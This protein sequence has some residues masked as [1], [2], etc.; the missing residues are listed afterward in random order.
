MS[1]Q[2]QGVTFRNCPRLYLGNRCPEK[3]SL[4]RLAS[5]SIT[6]PKT[7]FERKIKYEGVYLIIFGSIYR[8]MALLLYAVDLL[9]VPAW[10]DP[11]E[12]SASSTLHGLPRTSQT[13][14]VPVTYVIC[15]VTCLAIQSCA[16]FE[17]RIFLLEFISRNIGLWSPFYLDTLYNGSLR[18]SDENIVENFTHLWE[19]PILQVCRAAVVAS[20]ADGASC[21]LGVVVKGACYQHMW[22]SSGKKQLLY[23]KP[24]QPPSDSRLQHKC[25]D[26]TF[27]ARFKLKRRLSLAFSI[28]HYNQ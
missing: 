18:F 21:F 23:G 2:T 25:D 24:C 1:H 9:T 16:M 4:P 7:D 26:E 13:A 27:A 11:P 20:R 3:N 12:G 5:P 28:L 14:F 10:V 15:L 17:Y 19:E 6:T 22:R 8:G